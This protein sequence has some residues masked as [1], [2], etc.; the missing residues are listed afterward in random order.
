MTHNLSDRERAVAI[1]TAIMDL[2]KAVR[3]LR[4]AEVSNAV[5]DPITD[6]WMLATAAYRNI[7]EKL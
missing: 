5:I 7:F 6:G 2:D 3:A 4:R 1:A